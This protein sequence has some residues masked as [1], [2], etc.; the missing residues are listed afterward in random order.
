MYGDTSYRLL[1]CCVL[2][3]LAV[4]VIP[5]ATVSLYSH[6]TKHTQSTQQPFSLNAYAVVIVP[7]FLICLGVLTLVYTAKQPRHNLVGV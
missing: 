6:N 7:S 5:S 4:C 2:R 1:E 3:R